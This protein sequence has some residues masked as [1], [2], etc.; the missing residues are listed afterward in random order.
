MGFWIIWYTIGACF[1]GFFACVIIPKLVFK[2]KAAALPIC[3]R[4][5]GRS[6]DEHGDVL[7][8]EPA[9]SVRPYIRSYRIANDGKRPYFCGEWA[10]KI[11]CIRYELVVFNAANEIIDIIRVKETFNGGEETHITYLPKGA[12][13][14]SLRVL[15]VDDMALPDERRP[16]NGAYA[17]WLTVLSVAAAA[18]VDVFLWLITS[19]LLRLY[20]GFTMTAD[21]PME[22]WIAML[23]GT[24][25]VVA[26]AVWGVSALRFFL[27]RKRRSADE[28]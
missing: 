5:L 21:L 19:V 20:D 11:A 1:T 2:V 25:V 10:R 3:D 4:A 9:P 15:S 27:L 12:D 16:F 14:V 7:L 28:S 22:T 23:V 13:F 18:V 8:C 26:A 17:C 24:G 6:K